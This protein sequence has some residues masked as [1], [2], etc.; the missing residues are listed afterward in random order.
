MPE[1]TPKKKKNNFSDFLFDQ[2]CAYYP[3]AFARISR[4]VRLPAGRRSQIEYVGDPNSKLNLLIRSVCAKTLFIKTFIIIFIYIGSGSETGRFQYLIILKK[5]YLFLLDRR[6]GGNTYGKIIKVYAE[7]GN[8]WN[9]TDKNMKK[10]C[11]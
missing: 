11:I 7:F 5:I 2:S 3:H 10:K 9:V 8:T 1:R 6:N 4:F